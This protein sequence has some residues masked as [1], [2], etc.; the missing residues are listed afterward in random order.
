MLIKLF[1]YSS[2]TTENRTQIVH[3]RIMLMTDLWEA[4]ISVAVFGF[5]PRPRMYHP[6]RDR[7]IPLGTLTTSANLDVV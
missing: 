5:P 3:A 1:T 7:I 4:N 2:S 6:M